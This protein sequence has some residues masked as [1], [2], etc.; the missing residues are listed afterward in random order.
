M[1]LTSFSSVEKSLLSATIFLLLFSMPIGR[2]QTSN[3]SAAAPISNAQRGRAMPFE[4]VGNGYIF[5]PTRLNNAKPLW[6]SL[7][8]GAGTIIDAQQA[9][10]SGLKLKNNAMGSIAE[11]HFA[12]SMAEGVTINLSGL[13]LPDLTIPSYSLKSFEPAIGH[14]W[15]GVLG[16]EIFQRYV[17]EIDYAAKLIRFF[18]PAT[19]HYG[20][21]GEIVPITMENN[22]PY[23]L[24]R[25]AL[26]GHHIL[27][28][29]FLID[30]GADSALTFYTPFLEKNSLRGKI[31]N[32]ID[33]SGANPTSKS[34]LAIGRAQSIQLGKFVLSNP[35]AEF[36]QDT[37]GLLSDP[38]YAGLIGGGLLQR[39]KVIFDYSR[40]RLILEANNNFNDRFEYDMSGLRLRAQGDT[41][42]IFRVSRILPHSPAADAG[43]RKGD[44]ITA[45]NGRSSVAL[46]LDQLK[47][48]F[49]QEGR[50]YLLTL[51]RGEQ[52]RQVKIKLR[53]MV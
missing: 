41:F 24:A 9:R 34:S 31:K 33:E 43:L 50:E 40:R 46:T 7:D 44:L 23:V 52:T 28:G 18:D 51:K 20:G 45:I 49:R 2:A 37:K 21:G 32:S 48:L 12:M 1:R 25:V 4:L 27:E 42:K 10:A 16:Y 17:V 14:Y 35:L 13:N 3:N 5:L 29:R 36:S 38:K 47:H 19:F 11:S 39:F 15:D 6:F 30:T 53:R 26:P 22:F 8:T